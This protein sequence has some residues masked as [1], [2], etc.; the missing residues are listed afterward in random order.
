MTS[1]TFNIMKI[2]FNYIFLAVIIFFF[3]SS[4]QAQRSPL[5]FLGLTPGRVQTSF[6]YRL[7]GFNDRSVKQQN[8]DL[9]FIQHELNLTVPLQQNE[10]SNFTIFSGLSLMDIQSN[11]MLSDAAVKLPDKLWD[12]N[13]GG[14]YQYNFDDDKAAG[15]IISAGSPSD[16]P[17][18]QADVIAVNVTGT[19]KHPARGN[20]TW[21]F[22]LNYATNR[23]FLPNIPIPG[24]AYFWNPN[25][26]LKALV[27]IPFASAEYEFTDDLSLKASYL[28]PRTIHTEVNFQ[29]TDPVSLYSGFHWQNQRFFRAGRDDKDE[30]LFYYEKKLSG[31]IRLNLNNNIT[32]DIFS[33]YA[34]DRFF[35]EGEDYD[36]RSKNRIA[37]RDGF[38]AGIQSVIRF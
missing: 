2:K 31:G 6:D 23:E 25:P 8:A 24:F 32:L 22:F 33:G 29:L 35:F 27:G 19:L 26:K 21:L 4:S 10:Q 13:L 20:D 18:D 30:R 7:Q 28:I 14:S 16:K 9:A 15:L 37:F 5:E 12:I 11:A 17:F 3:E 38:F 1:F 34:F 36:D